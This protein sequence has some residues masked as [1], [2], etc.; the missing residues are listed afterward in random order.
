MPFL[1]RC[2]LSPCYAILRRDT[3]L[4]LMCVHQ[5]LPDPRPALRWDLRAVALS[6]VRGWSF[7]QNSGATRVLPVAQHCS[8]ALARGLRTGMREGVCGSPG[9]LVSPC[10]C[11]RSLCVQSNLRIQLRCCGVPQSLQSRFDVPSRKRYREYR[12]P[13]SRG[14]ERRFGRHSLQGEPQSA[15]EASGGADGQGQGHGGPG[16]GP[17]TFL[18]VAREEMNVLDQGK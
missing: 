12:S 13:A 11:G 4:V 3:H 15:A 9:P 16:A 8:V 17:C 1:T 5:G 6:G 2:L 7:K 18:R 14:W 10:T